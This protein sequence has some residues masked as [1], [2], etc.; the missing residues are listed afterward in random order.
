MLELKYWSP[1]SDASD[2]QSDNGTMAGWNYYEGA[3]C[4]IATNR[5]ES[6]LEGTTS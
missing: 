3:T 2:A 1:R 4:I 6:E 5:Q